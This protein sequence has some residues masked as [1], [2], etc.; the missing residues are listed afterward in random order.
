MRCIW[1]ALLILLLAAQCV[2]ADDKEPNEPN[3]PNDPKELLQA[4]WDTILLV[5]EKKD[6]DQ[7]AKEKEITKIVNP[8]FDFQVM[9]QLSLGRTHWPKLTPPQR[10]QFIKLFTE[11][12]IHSYVKKVMLY[13]NETILFKTAVPQKKER[14]IY[15]PVELI[16]KDKKINMLYKLRKT[17]PPKGDWKIYD[18]EIQGVSILLTYRAQ[19]DDILRNGTIKDLLSQLEKPPE[20]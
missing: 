2:N 4:K 6:A 10:E 18:V 8:I 7:Q 20:S 17:G 14:I 3:D 15:I 11:R 12:L 1:Y 19:F 9:A 16:S 5:V 13:T